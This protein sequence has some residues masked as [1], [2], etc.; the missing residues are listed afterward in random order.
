MTP[1]VTLALLPGTS[2][3]RERVV[4]ALAAR[5]A[6]LSAL[7]AG[8]SPVDDQGGWARAVLAEA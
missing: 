1:P 2:T 5:E 4:K 8:R 3:Q 7:E 6:S